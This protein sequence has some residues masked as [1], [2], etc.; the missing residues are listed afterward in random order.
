MRTIYKRRHYRKQALFRRSFYAPTP[1]EYLLAAGFATMAPEALV[2]MGLIVAVIGALGLAV[3][4]YA[5][6]QASL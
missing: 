6:I 4:M 5:Q 2:L 1:K 3:Y